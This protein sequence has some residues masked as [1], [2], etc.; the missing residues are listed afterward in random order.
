VAFAWP[1]SNGAVGGITPIESMRRLSQPTPV[2]P[3]ASGVVSPSVTRLRQIDLDEGLLAAEIERLTPSL[4]SR[5]RNGLLWSLS[6]FGEAS[7]TFLE[8]SLVETSPTGEAGGPVGE[9]A[10]GSAV[11]G[12]LVGG[13]LRLAVTGTVTE[14]IGDEILAFGHAFLGQG[15]IRLPMATAEVVTVLSN[16]FSSFKIANIGEVVGAFDLDLS[17]GVRG[18]VD[19]WVETIPMTITIAGLGAAT[20]EMELA[21][22]P[23]YLP[24]LVA[25][26]SVG[27]F[28]STSRSGGAQGVDLDVRWELE[29]HGEVAV[30]QSFD[31]SG[32]GFSAATYLLLFTNFLVNNAFEETRLESVSID[33]MQHPVPRTARILG[34]FANR[35]AARPGESVDVTL[36]IKPFRGEVRQQRLAIDLPD[37]LPEG[38]YS[39]IVGDGVTIDTVRQMVEQVE[40]QT[41]SQSLDMVRRFHSNRDLMAIGLVPASGLTFSGKVLPQLPGSMRRL[42]GAVPTGAARPLGLAVVQ[43]DVWPQEAPLTG[44]VRIDI[45]VRQARTIS[46][47]P[48]PPGA[49][50]GRWADSGLVRGR[51]VQTVAGAAELLADPPFDR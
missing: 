40:P 9:L 50:A 49:G 35:S 14:R 8:R 30:S 13:D 27:A 10:P 21:D 46:M 19:T 3:A 34:G 20:F 48:T 15:P 28:D 45:E 23:A 44:G 51:V 33:L 7:R 31:G 22:V 36:E 18:H 26:A 39:L 2:A 4:P 43:E 25:I 6:G 12:V 37:D 41:L 16:Q 24:T 17:S 1:F 42:W 11:A 47:I 29:R 32:A 5:A 38:R